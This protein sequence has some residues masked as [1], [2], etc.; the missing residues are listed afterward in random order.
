MKKT[1]FIPTDFSVESLQAACFA[2]QHNRQHCEALHLVLTH[3]MFLPD[4]PLEL[5][6]FSDSALIQALLTPEFSRARERL[7]RRHAE[8]QVSSVLALFTGCNQAAFT[9]FLA[10]HRI[11]EAVLPVP[12]LP[13]RNRR[14]SFSPVPFLRKSHLQITEMHQSASNGA[15][16]TWRVN[17]WMWA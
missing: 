13:R 8:Q 9:R 11:D 2:I 17:G 5:L 10:A 3:C 7:C 15:T 16:W 12:Y 14:N 1:I 4:C 6:F